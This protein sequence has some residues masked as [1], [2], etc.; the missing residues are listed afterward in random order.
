MHFCGDSQTVEVVIRSVISFNQISIYRAV[1]DVFD[2]LASRIS[3]RSASTVRLVVQVK[4]ETMVAP[5]DL[6]TTTN[7]LVTSEAAR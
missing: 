6:S 3:D 5:T 2:E 1:A 7:P 4:S